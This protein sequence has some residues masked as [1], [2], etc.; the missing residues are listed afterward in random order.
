MT[1]KPRGRGSASP[2]ARFAIRKGD[3]RG[4]YDSVGRAGGAAGRGE[5]GYASFARKRSRVE[6][7]VVDGVRLAVCEEEVRT[8][9]PHHEF[10]TRHAGSAAETSGQGARGAR[11]TRTV[12]CFPCTIYTWNN[13]NNKWKSNFPLVLKNLYVNNSLGN[14]KKV[15]ARFAYNL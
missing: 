4:G 9:H 3:C 5:R 15:W 10:M 11:R 8:F 13:R 12:F 6:E 14:H 7:R 1:S 2:V